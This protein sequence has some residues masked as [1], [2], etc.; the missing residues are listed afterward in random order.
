MDDDLVG[1]SV[2]DAAELRRMRRKLGNIRGGQG[3]A[4]YATHD[5]ITISA[6]PTTPNSTSAGGPPN[7]HFAVLVKQNG[8]SDGTPSTYA[9]WAYDLYY[10]VDTAYGTKLNGSGAIQPERSAARILKGPVVQ[11]TDGSAGVAYWDNSGVIHL[12][13]CQE[14][15]G[16]GSCA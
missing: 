12:W 7:K 4:V 9:S 5:G 10:L 6:S 15:H 13:D 1:L 8:G 16:S 14:K 2:G 11:A 3:I